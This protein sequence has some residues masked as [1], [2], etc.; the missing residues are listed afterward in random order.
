[1]ARERVGLGTEQRL[2]QLV[3]DARAAQLRKRILGRPRC[4]ERTVGQL[5]SWSM[6]ICDDEL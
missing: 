5:A 4:D 1:M 3:D 6:M 2:S